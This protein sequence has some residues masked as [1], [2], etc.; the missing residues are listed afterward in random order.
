MKNTLMNLFIIAYANDNDAWVAEQWAREALV[1]LTGNMQIGKLVNK[2]YSPLVANSGEVVNIN[3]P[4]KFKAIRKTDSD[5]I[6]IQDA[7][8]SQI[9]VAL[10]QHLHTSFQIKDGERSKSFTDLVNLYM[11]P[12]VIALAEQVDASLMAQIYQF[13][14]NQVGDLGVAASYATLV[15]A[16]EYM[17][18]KKVPLSGRNLILSPGMEGTFLKDAVLTQAQNVGENGQPIRTGEL[19]PRYGFNFATCQSAPSIAGV[20]SVTGAINNAA[21]YPKGHAGSMTVDG[22]AGEVKVGTFVQLGGH[23]YRVIARTGTAPTTAV[24]LDRSLDAA[25]ADNAVMLNFQNGTVGTTRAAKYS[26]QID[27]TNG[28]LKTGLLTAVNGTVYGQVPGA[29]AGFNMLERPLDFGITANDIV[30]YGPNGGFGFAFTR[31]A[32]TMVSRPL[33]MAPAGT[34]VQSAV[35]SYDGIALRATMGYDIKSQATI[36]TIDLLLGFA[37]TD[38][39][40][41]LLVLSNA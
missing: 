29:D 3:K 33:A 4:A 17:T 39:D 30:G 36:V 24:T 34:S 9:Q 23:Y 7:S 20:T 25:V 2:D 15:D 6:T 1:V 31:N 11:G 40:Q 8:S 41:G 12:A 27:V 10:N 18:A 32:L 37:K 22:F 14:N 16:K 38:E 13:S 26:K 21:G 35:M 28:V 5:D 19:G